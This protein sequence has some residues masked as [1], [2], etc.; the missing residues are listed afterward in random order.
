MCIKNDTC[1]FFLNALFSLCLHVLAAYYCFIY[2]TVVPLSSSIYLYYLSIK[3][4][5]RELVSNLLYILRIL[6]IVQSHYEGE[7]HDFA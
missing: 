2:E 5:V 1:R 6:L 3:Q 4:G 7:R